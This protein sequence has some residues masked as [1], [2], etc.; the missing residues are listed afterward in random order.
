M[1]PL[2]K[3]PAGEPPVGEA[4]V[5][6]APVGEAPVGEAPVGEAKES[7]PQRGSA[8]TRIPWLTG[9]PFRAHPLRRPLATPQS[10]GLQPGLLL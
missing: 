6:E 2:V 7:R 9:S 5:G 8:P 4:P 1:R 10:Q 3:A